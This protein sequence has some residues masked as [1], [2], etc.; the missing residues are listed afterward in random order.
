MQMTDLRDLTYDEL[1]N[2]MISLG[3]KKFRAG[4]IYKWLASGVES[5][6]EMTN[7]SSAL[8]EKLKKDYYIFE[9]KVVKKLESKID[10]PKNIFFHFMTGT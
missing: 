1:E 7:I 9:P 8:K 2:L 10:K 4:Q 3:E 5:F 6:E